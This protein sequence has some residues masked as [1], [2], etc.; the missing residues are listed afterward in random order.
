MDF[1]GKAYHYWKSVPLAPIR[2]GNIFC[3]IFFDV[4]GVQGEFYSRLLE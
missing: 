1:N 4:S 3:I 2:G